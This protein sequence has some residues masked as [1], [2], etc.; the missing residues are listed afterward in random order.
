MTP[1]DAIFAGSTYLVVGRPI[2]G[3]SDPALAAENIQREV[4]QAL[5]ELA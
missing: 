5:A 4:E 3:S 1:R 2:S